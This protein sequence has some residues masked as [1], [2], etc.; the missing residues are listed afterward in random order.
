MVRVLIPRVAK[1]AA[2][3]A[4]KKNNHMPHI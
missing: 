3:N 1:E 2:I 4:R